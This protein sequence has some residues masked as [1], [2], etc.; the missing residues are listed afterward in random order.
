MKWLKMKWVGV[1]CLGVEMIGIRW[2]ESFWF[3]SAW[4]FSLEFN[5]TT[6]ICSDTDDADQIDRMFLFKPF[7]KFLYL[8][9]AGNLM[10]VWDYC[11][12]MYSSRRLTGRMYR[13]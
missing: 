5:K 3:W 7:E 11:F 2:I 4:H 1:Y 10:L 12:Y 6:K 8:S 13:N 9:V